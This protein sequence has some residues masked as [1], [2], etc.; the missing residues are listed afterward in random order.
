MWTRWSILTSRLF[1]LLFTYYHYS[2]QGFAFK[3][4]TVLDIVL[5]FC[6]LSLILLKG[7]LRHVNVLS[8]Y[9]R[10]KND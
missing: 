2:N 1:K 7:R 9:L 5:Y 4:H 3:F 8:I 10:T 6:D